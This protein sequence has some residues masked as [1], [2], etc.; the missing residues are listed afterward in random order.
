MKKYTKDYSVE[1]DVNEKGKIVEKYKYIGKFYEMSLTKG[2]KLAYIKK[3]TVSVVIFITCFLFAGLLNTNGSRN[4]FIVLPY[5]TYLL[6]GMYLIMGLYSFAK[7]SGRMKHSD[8]DLSVCRMSK[9]IN[10]IMVISAYLFF[11]DLVF[12]SVKFQTIDVIKECLFVLL[13]GVILFTIRHMKALNKE[14][15]DMISSK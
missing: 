6:P 5:A 4:V 11:A 2:E 15:M 7:A 10:A 1:A 13:I 9:C 12:I 14:I 8:Y 3:L